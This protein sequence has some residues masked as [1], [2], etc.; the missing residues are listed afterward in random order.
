MGTVVK[1]MGT[2]VKSMGTVV[3]SMGTVV[4]RIFVF[5]QYSAFN[6]H[7]MHEF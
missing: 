2:V 7:N 6:P 5:A 1:S 3:K 4:S